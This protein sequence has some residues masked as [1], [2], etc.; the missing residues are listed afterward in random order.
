MISYRTCPTFQN[1][2][3]N[4][5]ISDLPSNSFTYVYGTQTLKTLQVDRERSIRATAQIQL[6]EILSEMQ[7][8]TI[9]CKVD[10]I[11]VPKEFK[12]HERLPVTIMARVS[13]RW[14][15]LNKIA[16]L[17]RT[18]KAIQPW[19]IAII[20]NLITLNINNSLIR[21]WAISIRLGKFWGWVLTRKSLAV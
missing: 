12:A 4:Q 7:F 21:G 13:T 1:L 3:P 11:W 2:F 17:N 8:R 10:Q 9:I 6:W 15:R 14:L 5:S 16:T 20:H 19:V 18:C